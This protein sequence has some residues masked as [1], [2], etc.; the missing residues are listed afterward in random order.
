MYLLIEIMIKVE[1][2]RKTA[3]H[4]HKKNA[5]KKFFISRNILERRVPYNENDRVKLK[6]QVASCNTS[7]NLMIN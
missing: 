4:T 2:E 3:T 7:L 5:A 1:K 6:L